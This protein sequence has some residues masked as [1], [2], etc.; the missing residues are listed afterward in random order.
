MQPKFGFG[1]RFSSVFPSQIIVD[2]SQLCNLKCIHCPYPTVSK[3][4]WWNFDQLDP[5]V[6]KKLIDEVASDGNG[7]CQYVRY[8]AN[9]EPLLNREFM[10]MVHYA[11]Q[12]LSPTDT[13]IN[14]TT[15]GTVLTDKKANLLIDAPID[16]IDISIDAYSEEAYAKIRKGNLRKVRANVEN[17]IK[18]IRERNAKT[19]VV[20]SFIEQPLNSGE[21][22]QFQDY[23]ES[24]GA[25]RV[26]IRQLHTAAGAVPKP[27]GAGDEAERYPCLYPWERVT[28]APDGNLYFCPQDWVHGSKIGDYAKT[29][30]KE[31]WRGPMMTSLRMAHLENNFAKHSFCGQ[32]P[33]WQHTNWPHQDG[34][35]YSDGMRELGEEF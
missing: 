8:T 34:K 12:Q 20:I 13:Q 31:I 7:I 28:L 24:Q 4:D 29:S 23:W 33:D 16:V 6:H 11:G 22:G 17:L 26:V 1:G 5:K 25:D 27:G 35:S 19:K 2:V 32:C 21:A 30:I 9:G 14:V 18:L 10:E 3:E 15:N